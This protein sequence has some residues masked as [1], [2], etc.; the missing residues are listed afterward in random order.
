MIVTN[1]FTQGLSRRVLVVADGSIFTN[2]I[3]AAP[4]WKGPQVPTNGMFNLLAAAVND[5]SIHSF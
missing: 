3:P 4:Q 2:I 1:I 5:N